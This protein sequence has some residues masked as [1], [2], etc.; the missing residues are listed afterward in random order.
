MGFLNAGTGTAKAGE[1][2]PAWGLALA[3]YSL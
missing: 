1:Q 3:F 2:A